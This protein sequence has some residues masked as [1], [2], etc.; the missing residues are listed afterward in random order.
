MPRKNS[1]YYQKSFYCSSKASF[2]FITGRTNDL[3]EREGRTASF[4][5]ESI[6]K[7][8]ILPKNSDAASLVEN[9][10]Y[11]E[12]GV[13]QTLETAFQNNAAGLNCKS[14]CGDFKPLVKFCLDF[15][16]TN[17]TCS[18]DEPILY[19]FRSQLESVVKKIENDAPQCIE[20]GDRKGFLEI[21]NHAKD[22]YNA[23]LKTPDKISIKAFFEVIYDCFEMLKDLSITYRCLADLVSMGTFEETVIAR[24]EL[25]NTIENVFSPDKVFEHADV[26]PYISCANTINLRVEASSR[27]NNDNMFDVFANDALVGTLFS[28]VEGW[29]NWMPDVFGGNPSFQFRNDET[30]YSVVQALKKYKNE[31][32]YQY[33]VIHAYNGGFVSCL[34]KDLLLKAGF[35]NRPD[36]DPSSM[37]LE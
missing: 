36:C 27:Y 33:L 15:L 28:N 31:N 6:I 20:M 35:K 2:N 17:S 1:N 23:S 24:N 26:S 8:R 5:I 29:L 7:N 37:F 12:N 25:F 21:A 16:A 32:G 18:G 19:H 9:F 14:V 22:L 4:I 30:F 10:L 11:E 3:A 34:D 13:K